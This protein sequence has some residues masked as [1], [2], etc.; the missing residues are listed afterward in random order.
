ML[1]LGRSASSRNRRDKA[2]R[3][4][5]SLPSETV[6]IRRISSEILKHLAPYNLNEDKAFEIRLSVEEAVRNAIVHGNKSD[7]HLSVKA[8]CWLEGG[9]INIQI[10][11]EGPGFGHKSLADP[12]SDDNV[13][14]NS[15]RGIFLIKKLMDRVEYNE[16]GN[17]LRMVKHLK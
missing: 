15:G 16:A 7:K 13:M 4:D 12:T 10:E 8:S 1:R 14:R 2:K 5:I 3:L 6:S 9:D 11:D 17:S